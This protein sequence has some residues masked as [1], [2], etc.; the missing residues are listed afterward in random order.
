MSFTGLVHAAQLDDSRNCP[1]LE[2]PL[3]SGESWDPKCLKCPK[4]VSEEGGF[5]SWFFTKVNKMGA[6]MPES[7]LPTNHNIFHGARFV[8]FFCVG[9]FVAHLTSA[10]VL[11]R[12]GLH[13]LY[14]QQS[15]LTFE[16][17]QFQG[18]P[19]PGEK[20]WALGFGRTC[21]TFGSRRGLKTWY[22]FF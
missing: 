4:D 20:W 7:R 1:G 9:I 19:N 17:D 22:I 14:S 3:I 21:A 16:G 8:W 13:P 6:K 18:H 12:A 11:R 10:V 5:G 15:M 2:G